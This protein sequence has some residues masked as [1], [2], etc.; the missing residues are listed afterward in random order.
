MFAA[1]LFPM[2]IAVGVLSMTIGVAGYP[3]AQSVSPCASQESIEGMICHDFYSERQARNVPIWVNSNLIQITDETPAYLDIN[4]SDGKLDLNPFIIQVTDMNLGHLAHRDT[5]ESVQDA[6]PS[7]KSIAFVPYI[8][9]PGA[10]VQTCTNFGAS[11]QAAL[12]SP[13]W[14][15]CSQLQEY[16]NSHPGYAGY[17]P[18]EP[19]SGTHTVLMSIPGCSVMVGRDGKQQPEKDGMWF[20]NTDIAQW[21]TMASQL[22]NGPHSGA[23]LVRGTADCGHALNMDKSTLQWAITRDD[24]WS[25]ARSQVEKRLEVADSEETSS[26]KAI[27]TIPYT[28]SPG[29]PKKHCSNTQSALQSAIHPPKWKPYCQDLVDYFTQHPGQYKVSPGVTLTGTRTTIAHNSGV[30]NDSCAVMVGRDPTPSVTPT[31]ETAGL[32]FGDQDVLSWLTSAARFLNKTIDG[33]GHVKGTADCDH[34]SGSGTSSL[35]W[36]VTQTD[37]WGYIPTKRDTVGHLRG[38]PWC[39]VRKGGCSPRGLERS[40]LEG[41]E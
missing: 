13:D 16:F 40:V 7:D 37:D 26:V 39:V 12:T 25:A 1:E 36:A 2:A 14:K 30:N 21:F 19:V 10:P 27:S 32:Y 3:Q 5:S 38:H 23:A 8:E 34:V 35:Q 6:L 20:G 15:A 24:N 31:P 11:L 9:M 4:T 41:L 29:K 33:S 22:L 17:N 18:G 28:E